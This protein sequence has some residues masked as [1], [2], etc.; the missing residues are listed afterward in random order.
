M[1]NADSNLTNYDMNIYEIS[2]MDYPS[3]LKVPPEKNFKK[4]K[5][6]VFVSSI[7]Y[8]SLTHETDLSPGMS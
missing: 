7:Y 8:L 2:S 1:S 6:R 5:Y 4:F 3:D